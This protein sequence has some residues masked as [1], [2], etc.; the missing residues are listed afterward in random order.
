MNPSQP[1]TTARSDNRDNPADA[2]PA[3]DR[4]A[5]LGDRVRSLRLPPEV[6]AHRSSSRVSWLFCLVMTG[7]AAT[8]GFLYY[9]QLQRNT[10]VAASASGAPATTAEP[11][12]AA[13]D[14]PATSTAT[15]TADGPIALEAKGYIV[16]RRTILVSPQ[17]N[18]RLLK[19]L[20]EEGARVKQDEVLAEVETTDYAADRDRA[21]AV[22]DSAQQRLLEM[23]RGNRADEKLQATKELQEAQIQLGQAEKEWKRNAAL[24]ET[25]TISQLE[26]EQSE[27]AYRALEEKVNR[28]AAA[29]RLM[30]EGPRQER[31]DAV[32]AEVKQLQ[33]ELVRAQWRLDNCTVKA[34]ISGTILRKNAEEGNIVNPIAFNGSYSLC[35]MADLSDLEVE[36]FIQERDI[37]RVFVGQSCQVRAE[38]YPDRTYEGTVSR[39][40]PIA[41]RAKGAVPVRVKLT[42]PAAEEGVYLKPEMGAIVTFLKGKDEGSP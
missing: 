11:S 27:A 41:D 9:Q 31:I 16:P 36:L 37:A 42:V 15:A 38:A 33:A 19:V 32:E 28:F 2:G 17:V 22:L 1:S 18:G 3:S 24:R 5:A 12:A 30:L 39:L 8:F 10:S 20:F 6:R 21:R 4:P 13:D 29:E 26:Y 40:M 25:N 14:P 7:A 35:E 23:R 34:P